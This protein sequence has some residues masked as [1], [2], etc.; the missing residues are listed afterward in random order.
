MDGLG[1]RVLAQRAH[2]LCAAHAARA[3]VA[4]LL[5]PL[6][7]ALRGRPG[8]RG[9]VGLPVLVLQLHGQLRG[10]RVHAGHAHRADHGGPAG[11]GAAV[12][13]A[14]GHGARGAG[15][16]VRGAWP[17][18]CAFACAGLAAG[19]DLV[20]G[21]LGARDQLQLGAQAPFPEAFCRRHGVRGLQPELQHRIVQTPAARALPIDLGFRLLL[22][23][24]DSRRADDGPVQLA[25]AA[26]PVVRGGPRQ[27][28]RVL[29]LAGDAPPMLGGS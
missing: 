15:L 13:G 19:P 10:R 27:G 21:V 3:P 12:H 24:C 2:G 23:P 29:Q 11:V 14:G 1:L 5:G 4:A 20:P 8:R 18:V 28:V 7:P 6:R 25:A 26:L 9:R 22:P 16:A 17:R